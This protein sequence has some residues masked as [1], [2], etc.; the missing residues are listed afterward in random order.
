MTD[1]LTD[2][3]IEA[4]RRDFESWMPSARSLHAALTPSEADFVAS[5]GTALPL[6]LDI[7]EEHARMR[8][9]LAQAREALADIDCTSYE[10]RDTVLAAIDEVL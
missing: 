9:V 10:Q 8:V 3:E 6:L 5:L 4:L 1:A 2:D 7:A